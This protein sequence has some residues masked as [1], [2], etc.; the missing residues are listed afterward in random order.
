MCSPRVG[1]DVVVKTKISSLLEIEP[2]ILSII[3]P[4]SLFGTF[5][6]KIVI[7]NMRLDIVGV[8]PTQLRTTAL[9]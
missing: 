2:F 5:N 8:I 3:Y 1:K 4:T 7:R 9:L 6:L